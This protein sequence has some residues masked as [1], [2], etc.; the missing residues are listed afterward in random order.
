MENDST[1]G[2]IKNE[3][4]GNVFKVDRIMTKLQINDLLDRISEID[5]FKI[6]EF[7][8]LFHS[9]SGT[10]ADLQEKQKRLVEIFTDYGLTN[11]D[12]EAIPGEDQE[13]KLRK[14]KRKTNIYLMNVCLFEAFKRSLLPSERMFHKTDTSFKIDDLL[15]PSTKFLTAATS[16]DDIKSIRQV[17]INR[18]Y[19]QNAAYSCYFNTNKEYTDEEKLVLNK[20]V[21]KRTFDLFLTCPDIVIEGKGG[22]KTSDIEK[23]NIVWAGESNSGAEYHCQYFF[24][25]YF[26]QPI[27]GFYAYVMYRYI[28]ETF[29]SYYAYY[30]IHKIGKPYSSNGRS[31]LK[32]VTQS[33]F[34][35][36]QYIQ[37]GDSETPKKDYENKN[38]KQFYKAK[39][40][41]KR[42]YSKR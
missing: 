40:S 6:N 19:Y 7:D 20:E 2:E 10:E 28:T 29:N 14:K 31:S 15:S 3:T 16:K 5:A 32:P 4:D 33:L 27:R 22:F 12:E 18:A 35:C 11:L 38:N 37:K 24:S 23:F 1:T 36:L 25:F 9:V 41:K 21:F 34:K 42:T 26:K 13:T 30:Q 17:E 8:D 39:S